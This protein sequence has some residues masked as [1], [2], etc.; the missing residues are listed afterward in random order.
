MRASE[1]ERLRYRCECEE[2]CAVLAV[3]VVVDDVSIPSFRGL[4]TLDRCM[5]AEVC[6]WILRSSLTHV[7]SEM[8]KVK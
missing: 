2:L 5:S 8:Q 6:K 1:R 4:W 3:V 7:R